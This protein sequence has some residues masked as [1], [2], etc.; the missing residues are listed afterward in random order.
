MFPD[1]LQC[2]NS[3]R[4]ILAWLDDYLL[5]IIVGTSLGIF[6]LV[7]GRSLPIRHNSRRRRR[8][9]AVWSDR[10]D[11]VYS[12][13]DPTVAERS[14][15]AASK[16]AERSAVVSFSFEKVYS[17]APSTL[18]PPPADIPNFVLAAEHYWDTAL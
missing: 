11:D 2:P 14:P 7:A 4:H 9:S 10:V 17:V 8:A 13:F 6:S 16:V 3:V 1:S 15:V 18:A 12:D 5:P